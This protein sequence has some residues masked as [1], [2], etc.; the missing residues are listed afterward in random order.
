M[1]TTTNSMVLMID[2]QEKLVKATNAETEAENARKM[3]EAANI[4]GLPVLVSEQYPKGLGST[5]LNISEKFSENTKIIEK[6]AFSLLREENALE[7]IKSY[8]KKQVILFGIE[9]H[10][11]VLQTAIELIKN[12]FEVYLIKNA[13]K[14]RQEFEHL[15]GIDAMKEH[16]VKIITLEIALFEL[17]ETSKHPQ[18]K[19]IQALIK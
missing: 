9:T 3:I 17:L 11:C 14:S 1:L 15:A 10:I 19:Q 18:F 5:V 7:T 16:G 6:S 12:G 8:G 13:S 2:V 4:L